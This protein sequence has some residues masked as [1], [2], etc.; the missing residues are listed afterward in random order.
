MAMSKISRYL[1]FKMQEELPSEI[2]PRGTVETH[3]RSNGVSE[4]HHRIKDNLQGLASI[5]I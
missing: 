2:M 5:L 1:G 3:H 4:I